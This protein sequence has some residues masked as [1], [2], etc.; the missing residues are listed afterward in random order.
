MIV[1]IADFRAAIPAA[2]YR[3]APGP[4]PESAPR[5]TPVNGGRDRGFS[6]SEKKVRVARLQNEVCHESAHR[7]LVT[8]L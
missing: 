5:S 3:G 4:G 7:A 8:V 1:F 6:G 2:I